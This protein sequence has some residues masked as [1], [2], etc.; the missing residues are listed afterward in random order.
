MSTFQQK[1]KGVTL[2]EILLVLAI[3]SS[4]LIMVLNYTT[5]KADELR[6]DKTVLQIQQLLNAGMSFYVNKSFWP[7]SN[8]TITDAKCG[9]STWSDLSSLKPDFIPDSLSN[10]SYG[11]A[12]QLNCNNVG[13]FFVMTETN[14][15]ANAKVIVG[16]LPMAYRT[17]SQD[18]STFPPPLCEYGDDC[19]IVVSRVNIPGQNLNNARSV[20]FASTY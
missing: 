20:N 7:M 15:A 4:L 9:T 11:K 17:R 14:S 18:L 8:A 5:Q 3:A 19:D 2:L 6:R 12:Y 1:I 16:R 10:S 13:S